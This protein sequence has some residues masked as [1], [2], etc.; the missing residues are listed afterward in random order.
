[1]PEQPRQTVFS[2][3]E[4]A[5]ALRTLRAVGMAHTASANALEHERKARI[6]AVRAARLHGW[7][8]D[9][10]GRALNMTRSAANKLFAPSTT[11]IDHPDGAG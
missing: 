10:V 6:E 11:D 9:D 3:R 4:R 8:W 7:S 2:N 5:A 1:M